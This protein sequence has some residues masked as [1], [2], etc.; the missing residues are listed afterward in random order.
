MNNNLQIF[1]C[2]GAASISAAIIKN[3]GE[4][5][6]C[7]AYFVNFSSGELK[8]TLSESV[9]GRHCWVVQ[10]YNR[11]YG[12]D[13]I[14]QFYEAKALL[15]TLKDCHAASWNLVMPYLPNTRQERQWGREGYLF[16][17]IVD[18]L[19]LLGVKDII[20]FDLHDGATASL[21]DGHCTHLF[22]SHTLI[23][24]L[25]QDYNFDVVCAADTGAAKLAEF[26]A[27]RFGCELAVLAK[28]CKRQAAGREVVDHKLAGNVS[29][30]R[31]LIVDELCDT[32]GT[33]ISGAEFLLEQGGAAEIFLVVVH[34]IGAKDCRERLVRFCQKPEVKGY[35]TTDSI[36][37]PAGFFDGIPKAKI[38][39]LAPMIAETIKNIHSGGSVAGA[40]L[41]E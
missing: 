26:Y 17:M 8:F 12:N 18:E 3:L 13:L 22:T 20:T 30:K 24:Q 41:V 32:G 21:F 5:T 27:R 35:Y 9:R 31:V 38:I 2:P 4:P 10:V 40:Y 19:L 14:K 29:Q 25:K 33:L 39:S 36:L 16:K 11:G 1:G 34:T 6:P 15:R 37:Q 7:Q 28:G 23:P